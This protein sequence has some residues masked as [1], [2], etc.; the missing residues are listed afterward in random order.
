MNSLQLEETHHD[1]KYVY[2]FLFIAVSC[3]KLD[4]NAGPDKNVKPDKIESLKIQTSEMQDGFV[5]Y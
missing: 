2:I 4:Q 3:F 5:L 1:K